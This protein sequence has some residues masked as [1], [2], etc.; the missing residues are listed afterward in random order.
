MQPI[1]AIENIF[2]GLFQF[3]FTGRVE[4]T[5]IATESENENTNPTPQDGDSNFVSN[6]SSQEPILDEN[7][8]QTTATTT[9]DDGEEATVRTPL[10]SDSESNME[11]PVAVT[12]IK[13][14][15]LLQKEADINN[16]TTSNGNGALL[17][18]A[19]AAGL[20]GENS[21]S[22]CLR[23]SEG[24]DEEASPVINHLTGNNYYNGLNTKVANL[25][26]VF[27]VMLQ[28]TTPL[29]IAEPALLLPQY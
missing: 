26:F 12:A 28:V 8:T 6:D 11:P 7:T 17:V 13:N 10:A 1:V 4:S 29:L 3:L 22:N 23:D 25:H 14:S 19:S 24:D 18:A 27:H 21:D 20:D 15:S 5:N 16:P 9:S 2:Y